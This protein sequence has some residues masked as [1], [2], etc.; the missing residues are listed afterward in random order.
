[1]ITT[2]NGKIL[3]NEQ[4]A[5]QWL[6]NNCPIPFLCSADYAAGTEIGL[7]TIVNPTPAK[8]KIGSLIFFADSKVS[9]VVGLTANGF[10]CSDQYNDLVDDIVYV[11]NVQI[12][13]SGHLIVT[14]S[15]GTDI[16]AGLIKQVAGFSINASQHLIVS[17][18]DGTTTDLGAIFNGN[19]TISG[20]LTATG[21]MEQQTAN[22]SAEVNIVPFTERL[23]V[24]LAFGRIEQLNQTL[25]IV[26]QMRGEQTGVT[27]SETILTYNDVSLPPEIASKIYDIEGHTV[28]GQYNAPITSVPI[29]IRNRTQNTTHRGLMNIN[30]INAYYQMRIL[31]LFESGTTINNGDIVEIYARVALTLL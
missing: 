13:A 10:I 25:H 2:P 12:N 27:A 4:E 22:Y 3:M 14:L 24:S 8:V 9:T 18:N 6:L 17:Y 11:S 23:T 15:N 30:N 29:V 1:M 26:L 16:D 31:T 28:V 19:V 21:K 20:N 5:I 7:G